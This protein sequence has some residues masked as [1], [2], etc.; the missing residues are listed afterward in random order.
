[1]WEESVKTISYFKALSIGAPS[2]GEIER[3][4]HSATPASNEPLPRIPRLLKYARPNIGEATAM[5]EQK[6]SFPVRR[7]ATSRWEQSGK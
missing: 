4:Y 7:L 2:D 5:P 1:M 3:G 6:K